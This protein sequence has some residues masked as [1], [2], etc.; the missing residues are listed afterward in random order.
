MK[1]PNNFDLNAIMPK[2]INN[3]PKATPKPPSNTMQK[4]QN[5][6]NDFKNVN[7]SPNTGKSQ[8]PPQ[9][10]KCGSK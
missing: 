6:R 1:M 8:N 10:K 5:F 4:T 9:C 7:K 2:F 3:K